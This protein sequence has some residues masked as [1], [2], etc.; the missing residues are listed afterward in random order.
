VSSPSHPQGRSFS[1]GQ[2]D[3]N[4]EPLCFIVI[5]RKLDQT[6]TEV[7]VEGADAYT[8]AGMRASVK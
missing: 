6:V 2:T 7:E 1:G 4:V 3:L 5:L 8:S